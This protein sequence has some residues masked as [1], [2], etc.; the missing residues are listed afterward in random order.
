MNR[1]LLTYD[2]L[3]RLIGA[4][5][6]G[7]GQLLEPIQSYCLKKK[8][9]ALTAL[10]VKKSGTPGVG[11]IAAEDLPAEFQKVFMYSGSYIACS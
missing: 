4:D 8:L 3:S 7:L 10:V 1:Q 11:F 2:L 6:R 9:P 5:R